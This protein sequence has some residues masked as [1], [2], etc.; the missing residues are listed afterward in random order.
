MVD[1]MV[2]MTLLTTGCIGIVFQKSLTMDAPDIIG[3]LVGVAASAI[4]RIQST[5]IHV[6][7]IIVIC[8]RVARN[9]GVVVVHGI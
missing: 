7:K 3:H 8:I 4:D 9:T 1:V 2:P 6:G 5:P